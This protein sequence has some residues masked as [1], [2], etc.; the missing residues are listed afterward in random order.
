VVR[1][2]VVLPATFKD[3][4]EVLADVRA[5]EAAGADMLLLDGDGPDRLAI[6]GA[7]ALATE[8]IKLR[9][10]E[11]DPVATLRRLSGGRATSEHEP[12]ERWVEADVPPHREGWAALLREK[13]EAGVTGIV[14]R[15][16]PRLIDLLRNPEP[17]DRSDLLMSTG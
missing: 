2:G 5:L 4:G 14:V 1:I 13:E 10:S 8:R 15:W 7:I 12:G 3:A 17:D 9:I 16:D 6:L 11:V